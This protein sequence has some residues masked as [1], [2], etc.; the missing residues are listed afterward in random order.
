MYEL[1]PTSCLLV[2]EPPILEPALRE[3]L[4]GTGASAH[5]LCAEACRRLK[6]AEI[7]GMV[8]RNVPLTANRA[9]RGIGLATATGLRLF[10]ENW[11]ADT[12]K[13]L[14][15]SIRRDISL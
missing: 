4:F 9:I 7:A 12:C 15:R 8:A 10:V 13:R 3:G 2:R 11:D 5:S 14:D 1:G 6:S